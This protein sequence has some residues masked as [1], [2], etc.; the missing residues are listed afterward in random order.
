MIKYKKVRKNKKKY[1]FIQKTLKFI[2]IS[3]IFFL[4]NKL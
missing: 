2:K 1:F 4:L 3:E